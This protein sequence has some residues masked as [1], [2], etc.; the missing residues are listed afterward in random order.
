MDLLFQNLW[1]CFGKKILVFNVHCGISKGL[2]NTNLEAGQGIARD[3]R[4]G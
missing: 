2:E 1:G 4:V 3:A